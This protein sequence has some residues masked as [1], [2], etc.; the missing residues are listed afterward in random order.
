MSDIIKKMKV[1]ITGFE[2]IKGHPDKIDHENPSEK[3][4]NF[5]VQTKKNDAD[6]IGKILPVSFRKAN[7]KLFRLLDNIKPD[8][9]IMFGYHRKANY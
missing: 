9:L 5:V 2:P 3:I 7:R 8:Y 6:I 4:I 1:L